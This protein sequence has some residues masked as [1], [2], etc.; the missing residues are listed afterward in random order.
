M[1]ILSISL[2]PMDSFCTILLALGML[3]WGRWW[4][5]NGANSFEENSPHC[6]L[7]C[8]RWNKSCYYFF[9]QL[10]SLNNLHPNVYFYIHN[11]EKT[12]FSVVQGPVKTQNSE[13]TNKLVYP[14]LHREIHSPKD[15]HYGHTTSWKLKN[16]Y[17]QTTGSPSFDDNLRNH[18]LLDKRFGSVLESRGEAVSPES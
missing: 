5:C 16:I 17:G 14:V 6:S 9:S 1:R 10:L 18:L 12:I 7:I 3:W 13:K 8:L 4:C 2:T 15:N 11:V